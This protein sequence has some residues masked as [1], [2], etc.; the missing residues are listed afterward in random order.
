MRR[1]K[2]EGTLPSMPSRRF[3]SHPI[4]SLVTYRCAWVWGVVGITTPP[5]DGKKSGVSVEETLGD[6]RSPHLAIRRMLV[7]DR[8]GLG[9][10]GEE[11]GM[12]RRKGGLKRD[13]GVF[14]MDS[15][16]ELS[17]GVSLSSYT[18]RAF[19]CV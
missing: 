16:V 19:R 7:S 5:R 12:M 8:S 4:C 10:E 3:F 15:G 2:R 18:H 9:R 17:V 11:S 6:L 1:R 14:F 13:G